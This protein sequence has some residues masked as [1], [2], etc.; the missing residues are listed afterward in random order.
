MYD[1]VYWQFNNLYPIFYR[2]QGNLINYFLYPDGPLCLSD[3][4]GQV[5][6]FHLN[7]WHLQLL[8]LKD[9]IF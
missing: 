6:Q 7:H 4:L 9:S 1:S 2:K 3:T 8:K 5:V